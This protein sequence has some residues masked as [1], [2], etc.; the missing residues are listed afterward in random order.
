MIRVTFSGPRADISSA[1]IP[2]F[3]LNFELIAVRSSLLAGMPTTTVPSFFAA[4]NVFS[5]S[6]CHSAAGDGTAPIKASNRWT[7]KTLNGIG[8]IDPIT[9]R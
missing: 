9:S 2:Y 8:F 5:H 1:E 6:V 7:K 3:S 4:A